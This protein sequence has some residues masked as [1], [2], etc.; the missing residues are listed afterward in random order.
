M[1]RRYS[2]IGFNIVFTIG[3]TVPFVHFAWL[4]VVCVFCSQP[5]PLGFLLPQTNDGQ[6][7]FISVYRTKY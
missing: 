2:K 4:V 3:F 5:F 7:F 6:I 1:Q